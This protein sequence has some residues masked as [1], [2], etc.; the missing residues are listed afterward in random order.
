[1]F[2]TKSVSIDWAGRK[3]TLETGRVARQAD[4][5]FLREIGPTE[6]IRVC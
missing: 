3:L 4:D 6:K 1:M 2:D 5:Q